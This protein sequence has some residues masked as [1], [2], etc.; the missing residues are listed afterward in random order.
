MPDPNPLRFQTQNLARQ[1]FA[2]ALDAIDTA[3]SK[4][5]SVY[6]GVGDGLSPLENAPWRSRIERESEERAKINAELLLAQK[7]AD[8]IKRQL[9]GV[10]MQLSGVKRQLLGVKRQLSR[11]KRQ[12]SAIY[13]SRSW[14]ATAPLRGMSE[15]ARNSLNPRKFAAWLRQRKAPWL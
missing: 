9:S 3:S 6:Q 7:Q 11:V 15:F 12:L 1:R 4:I 5:V 8:V 13:N 14:Q 10:K 2:A